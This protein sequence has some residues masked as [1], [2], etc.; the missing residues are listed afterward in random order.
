M[1]SPSTSLQKSSAELHVPSAYWESIAMSKDTLIV[2]ASWMSKS[3]WSFPQ[4]AS[5]M[6]KGRRSAARSLRRKEMLFMVPPSGSALGSV[7]GARRS[8]SRTAYRRGRH[9]AVGR[10]PH[11]QGAHLQKGSAIRTGRPLLLPEHQHAAADHP[12]AEPCREVPVADGQ[13]E[14]AG[15]DVVGDQV[16]Q[17]QDQQHHRSGGEPG[18]VLGRGG[19]PAA[20]GAGALGRGGPLHRGGARGVLRLLGDVAAAGLLARR[21]APL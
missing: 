21:R 16:G 20:G 6:R 7:D 15:G 9:G 10:T 3:A 1:V 14:L 8:T 11:R 5:T 19:D 12:H 13:R 4:P 17:A 2:S 18:G